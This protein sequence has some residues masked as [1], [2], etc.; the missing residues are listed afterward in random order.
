MRTSDRSI[1]FGSMLPRPP[2]RVVERVDDE[3]R[4]DDHGGRRADEHGLRARALGAVREEE[5]ER[6]HHARGEEEHEP[7][8]GGDDPGRA[9]DPVASCLLAVGGLVEPLA[10]RRLLGRRPRLDRVQGAEE[11]EAP[12]VDR[13]ARAAGLHLGPLPVDDV[14]AVAEELAAEARADALREEL[15][16]LE[17]LDDGQRLSLAAGPRLVV[18]REGQEHDE[19]GE[20][21]EPGR[22]HAEDAR[23][24]VAVREVAPL[25][26]AAADE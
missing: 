11:R 10:V 8:G 12:R 1:A 21:R 19:A 15:R 6:E 13:A 5:H 24:A 16:R 20:D 22:E 26:R 17:L 3:Q 7:D 18:A 23:R 9:V 2:V 25:R 14:A 4:R